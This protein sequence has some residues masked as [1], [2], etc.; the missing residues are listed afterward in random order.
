MVVANVF[1][2]ITEARNPTAADFEPWSPSSPLKGS[3]GRAYGAFANMCLPI[4]G[5]LWTLPMKLR[6]GLGNLLRQRLTGDV[7]CGA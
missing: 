7:R 5:L 4:W 3:T 1:V 2:S 6:E